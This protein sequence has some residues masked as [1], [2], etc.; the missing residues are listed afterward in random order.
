M[1][2]LGGGTI[3]HVDVH[4]GD[5][6]KAAAFD[7]N[8][9]FI[10]HF[11]RLENLATGAEHHGVGEAV[12]DEGERHE[13]I[14]DGREGRA[15]ELEHIHL[16]AGGREIIEEGSD[17]LARVRV[18]IER[19]VDGIDADN[20]EGLLLQNI[21]FVPHAHVQDDVA[22]RATGRGLKTNTQPAVGLVRALEISRR[23][24]VGENKKGRPLAPLLREAR[25]QQIVFVVQHERETLLGDIA[26]GLAVNG[27][28]E[29]H[30]I[31]GNR[32]R[33]GTRGGAGLEKHAGD[34]LPGANF[35]ERA[36]DGLIEV[37]R[38]RLAVGG[39]K[40]FLLLLAHRRLL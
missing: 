2:E 14:V 36:I 21:F 35:G 3:Q 9:L 5:G 31:S 22:G 26:G 33:D 23:D 13:A 17:E 1:D 40:F 29:R 6:A 15:S 25:D 32:F 10:E 39:E 37:D 28:A 24:C 4:V 11:R 16:D 20:T 12:L 19:P 38:Q 27:I 34:L 30:V 18:V 8:G 7:E